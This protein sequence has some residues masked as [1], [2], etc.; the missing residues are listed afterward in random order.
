[1]RPSTHCSLPAWRFRVI[2]VRERTL[3]SPRESREIWR[4]S[5]LILARWRGWK[6]RSSLPDWII[7]CTWRYFAGLGILLG[8]QQL[9]FLL[10]TTRSLLFFFSL[11]FCFHFSFCWNLNFAPRMDSSRKVWKLF[12]FLFFFFLL[13]L[14]STI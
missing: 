5:W 10:P 6:T 14:F 4:R 3:V 12:L 8:T 7:T 9:G 13:F 1:M 11:P 2:V